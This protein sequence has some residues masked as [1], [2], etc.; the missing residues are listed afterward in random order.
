M[1]RLTGTS[2]LRPDM[3]KC[4]FGLL[5]AREGESEYT[6]K[7]IEVNSVER[8]K[9]KRDRLNAEVRFKMMNCGQARLRLFS[10]PP[11]PF[12]TQPG[13]IYSNINSETNTIMAFTYALWSSREQ[14]C[15]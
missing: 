4:D 15:R 9:V 14:R 11:K 12:E 2:I 7:A 3:M 1:T 6:R 10:S 5:Q 8:T 13:A